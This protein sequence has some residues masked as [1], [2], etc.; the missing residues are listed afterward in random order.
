MKA[1]GIFEIKTKLSQICDDVARTGE[2][3]LVTKRGKPLVRIEPL[4]ASAHAGSEVWE[5]RNSYLSTHDI[6]EDYQ[7]PERS[8]DPLYSPFDKEDI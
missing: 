4:S 5:A 2:S 7:E 6:D 3:V 1:L 8:S